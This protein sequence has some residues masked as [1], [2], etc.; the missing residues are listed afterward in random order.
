MELFRSVGLVLAASLLLAAGPPAGPMLGFGP[1][2]AARERVNEGLFLDLPSAQGALDHLDMLGTRPHYAGTRADRAMAEY[3][4]DRLAEYGFDAR[5]EPFQTEVQ[6]PYKLVL[7]LYSDGQ[8]YRP[9]DGFHKAHGHPG[10]GLDL[11]EA[12]DPRDPATLDPAVGLPFNAGSGDGNLNAPLVYANRGLPGDFAALRAAHVDVR[13]AVVLIRYGAAYRGQLA[14]NAQDAGAAGVV[15]YNDPADDGYARGA[16]I[17]AGPWRPTQSVQR[18]SLSP[19]IHIPVLPTSADNARILLRA[20]KGAPGPAGWAGALDAP[21]PVGKGPAVVH[22]QVI[23]NHRTATLWNTVGVLHGTLPTENVVVGAHRDAWVYGVGDNGA[24]TSTLLETARGLGYLARSGWR[25]RRTIVVALWDGEEIGLRGSSA[26]ALAH[27]AE[28]RR[29]CV[30]YVNAD[31]NVTGPTLGTAAV[32]A[33]APAIVDATRAVADPARDVSTLHDRWS[34]QPHGIDVRTV[35]GG[36]DHEAFL[37]GFGTPVAEIGFNGPFGPYH[38]S[39]DTVQYASTFS[40]PGL[41]LHRTAAQLFGIVAMRLA[42]ADAVPYSF[43]AYVPVLQSGFMQLQARSQRDGRTLDLSTLR[44]AIDR[45]TTSARRAD[46]GLVYGAGPGTERALMVAQTIDGL[47]YGVDGYASLSFPQL[48]KA[49]A[50]ND[51][52]AFAA[53]LD[54]TRASLDRATAALNGVPATPG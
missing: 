38:S 49:Y 44:G 28:L 27:A 33:L 54:D 1:I 48:T 16:T 20:L 8:V 18:G 22:L 35:G 45:F 3:A 26:Y 47:A 11:R 32:G 37:F 24:G 51:A 29:G 14:H 12:G 52:T 46:D 31:E 9:G 34:A 39:Y 10:I 15:F 36:S 13:G 30:A 17:P 43:A 53:A 41:V 25:P 50:T 5:I 40:D 4:R 19:G 2:S 23:M 7:E 6:T 42:D 21:Y